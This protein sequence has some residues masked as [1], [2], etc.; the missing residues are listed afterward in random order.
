MSLALKSL[1]PSGINFQVQNIAH[2]GRKEDLLEGHC[3]V[4]E[5]F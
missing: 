3:G 1:T 4:S 5:S 2:L